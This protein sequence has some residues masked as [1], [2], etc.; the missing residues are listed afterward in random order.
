MKKKIVL[1]LTVLFSA[2]MFAGCNS[3]VWLYQ[4]PGDE[5]TELVLEFLL[6]KNEVGA[7]ESSAEDAEAAK[8]NGYLR[9]LGYLSDARKGTPW[10]VEQYISAVMGTRTNME[11][12]DRQENST[13]VALFFGM[14]VG[15]EPDDEGDADEEE[16]GD[17]DMTVE[18]GFFVYKIRVEQEG[19]FNSYKREFYKDDKNDNSALGVIKNGFYLVQSVKVGSEE[20]NSLK[21]FGAEE[22]EPDGEGLVTLTLEI[23]PSFERAFPLAGKDSGVDTYLPSS[24]KTKFALCTDSKMKTSGERLQDQEGNKYY[25]F[26][27]FF[28]EKEDKIVYEYVRA[29]SV[30]WNVITICIGLA[31]VGI[32]LL[33]CKFGKPKEPK[34]TTYAQAKERFPY[35]P[36]ESADPFAEYNTK[37]NGDDN[38]PFAGY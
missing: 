14:T 28:D 7:L 20:Y 3:E 27:S 16:T 18:K 19:A 13:S 9:S 33:Y 38:D 37:K 12:V 6:N 21:Q 2:F 1:I 36:Y 11:F 22:S 24:L 30:G 4:Y 34:K 29:N 25:V 5:S 26:S 15:N 10:T 17:S 32:L 8:H 31:V 23:I 35:D